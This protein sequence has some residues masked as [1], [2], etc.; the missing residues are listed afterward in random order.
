M[1]FN[2]KKFEMHVHTAENDIFATEK[3]KDIVR[4]YKEAGYSGLVITDH[5]FS[6]FYDWFKTELAGA[7]HERIIDR[8]LRGY[9]SA[10][11]EGEKQGIVVLA[12]AEVRFDGTINDYLVY[13]LQPR[14]FYELPLLNKLKGV[15]ELLEVLPKDVCVVQA[16]P[17]RNDMVVSDPSNLFGIEVYNGGT[18]CFRNQIAKSFAKYYD[19]KMLSGSDFHYV[20]ACAK[21]GIYTEREIL[22]EKDLVSVLRSGDYGLIENGEI[23][24]KEK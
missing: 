9:N 7:S 16:H 10:R 20:D 15:N 5:Y 18:D 6:L 1:G 8:W 13:G 14:D 22:T 23:V 17:F 21:G 4:L 3:A 24:I 12:G 2:M 11:E 19:K